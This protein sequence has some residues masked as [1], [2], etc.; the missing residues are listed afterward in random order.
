MEET[1][2][3]ARSPKTALAYVLI[4]AGKLAAYLVT[5]VMAMLPSAPH[6]ERRSLSRASCSPPTSTDGSDTGRLV[7]RT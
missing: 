5:G 2:Q 1:D 6:L 4:F 7:A 3:D